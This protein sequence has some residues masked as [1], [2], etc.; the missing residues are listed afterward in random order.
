VAKALEE[1]GFAAVAL[2]GG[3]TQSQREK[4][5]GSFR[6][7]TNNVLVAT[8]VAARGLDVKVGRDQ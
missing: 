3:M 6:S 2:Q 4:A 8:D 1:K 5:I 7:G